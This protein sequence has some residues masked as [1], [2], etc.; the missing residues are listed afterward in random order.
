MLPH[1]Q[2]SSP[3]SP[4]SKLDFA[5]AY[6]FEC[7]TFESIPTNGPAPSLQQLSNLQFDE[8]GDE[9]SITQ[10]GPRT[11]T[12]VA[13]HAHV[14]P[15]PSQLQ[16]QMASCSGSPSAS[17]AFPSP[18]YPQSQFTYSKIPFTCE[19]HP[20]FPS[21]PCYSA[22][23][24]GVLS[25][26]IRQEDDPNSA[27]SNSTT[28]HY[29]PQQPLQNHLHGLSQSLLP[30]LVPV[31]STPVSESHQPGAALQPPHPMHS[32]ACSSFAPPPCSFSDS[33]VSSPWPSSH[34]N[35]SHAAAG[36]S[37]WSAPPLPVAG[38]PA[39][40]TYPPGTSRFLSAPPS[41]AP[42]EL[43]VGQLSLRHFHAGVMTS[44][45]PL[46]ILETAPQRS[47]MACTCP[48]CASGAN[49]QATNA[50]G[51]PRTK[52]HVCHYA[53]CSKVYSKT[54]HLRAHLRSHICRDTGERPFM[55]HWLYC[56]KRFT[57]SDELL[58]HLHTHTGVKRHVCDECGKGFMR[59]D[60]F[61]RHMQTHQKL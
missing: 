52:Q 37:P 14:N 26:G 55:C 20:T 38:R 59:S 9:I 53:N 49:S 46:Q 1:L 50:D 36:P 15:A 61:H 17:C 5:A 11:C 34:H 51:S 6:D 40:F 45:W 23:V 32:P 18:P 56:G 57:R 47:R 42:R 29:I 24:T 43:H 7:S 21:P 19:V 2:T 31:C 10:P 58:R 60:H 3:L 13:Q 30:P 27:V 8:L 33:S 39:A 25:P 4:L 44:M 16:V 35:T 12:P 28:R 54:S 22:S 48:N 41:G